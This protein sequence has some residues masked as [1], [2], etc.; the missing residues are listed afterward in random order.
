MICSSGYMYFMVFRISFLYRL[1]IALLMYFSLYFTSNIKL[2]SN[3]KIL[4]R[5]VYLA[6][7]R[8]KSNFC[9]I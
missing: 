5:L 3:M 1:A 8:T 2:S 7:N 9:N 6:A 4:N